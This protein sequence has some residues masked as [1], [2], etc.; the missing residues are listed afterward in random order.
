MRVG[1]KY[2]ERHDKA[3]AATAAAAALTAHKERI[4]GRSAHKVKAGH[5]HL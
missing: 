4:N 3:A 2:L 1:T 5:G